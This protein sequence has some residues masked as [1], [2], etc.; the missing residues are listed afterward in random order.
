MFSRHLALRVRRL[1]KKTLSKHR[2]YR[3]SGITGATPA[4]MRASKINAR[5]GTCRR[6]H[7]QTATDGKNGWDDRGEGAVDMAHIFARAQ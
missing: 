7:H 1:K 2:R 6:A 3:L 4:L 5:A